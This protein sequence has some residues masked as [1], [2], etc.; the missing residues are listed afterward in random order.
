MS[1]ISYYDPTPQQ[2]M[3]IEYG[4]AM[5]AQCEANELFP[6]DDEMWNAAVTCGNKLVGVGTTWSK[7][8]S[9]DDL[10]SNEKKALLYYLENNA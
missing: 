2:K 6:K 10:S 8:N 1:N 4:R 5:I 9:I 3:L 7:F